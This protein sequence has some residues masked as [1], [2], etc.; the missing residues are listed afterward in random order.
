MSRMTAAQII[1]IGE[2]LN[3]DFDPSSLTVP[4]LLGVFGYHNVNYPSQ[5][6]KAKLVQLFNEEIKP[7]VGKF[8]KERLKRE[9]S[10]ASDDGIKDGITGKPISESKKPVRR[11]SRRSSQAP[12]QAQEPD[13]EPAASKRRRSSA[14]PSL[15]GPSRRKTAKPAEPVVIEESEPEE[16]IVIRKV[17]RSKKSTTDA[18]TQ[19][20]RISQAFAEDSGWEDNNV[21]QSGA[22]SSSPL[23]PSP[24]RTR[25]RRTSVAS[26]LP[27]KSRKSMSAP[28]QYE[29]ASPEKG[30]Q[31]EILKERARSIKPPS[32]RFEPR[33]PPGIARETRATTS[34]ATRTP[35]PE[36]SDERKIIVIPDDVK[37]EEE[38]SDMEM[39][40]LEAL[41][42]SI[43]GPTL[44]PLEV[45]DVIQEEAVVAED[46]DGEDGE[47]QEEV[48][49]VSQ[50]IS[51]GGRIVSRERPSGPG[52]ASLLLRVM[53]VLLALGGSGLFYG[54][55][56]E[57][58]QI[59]FCEAGK[60]SNVI[61]DALRARRA[62]I[63]SCNEHNRTSLYPP[64][65]TLPVSFAEPTPTPQ[66][67][68]GTQD[69]AVYMSDAELC[70]PLPLLP[71]P[72]A[73]ACTP[74][75]RHA[76]CVPD[77]VTCDS[78]YVLK[79]HPLL[80]FMPVPGTAPLSSPS[81]R[82]LTTFTRPGSI[83]SPS[84]DLP[85]LVYSAVSMVLDGVPGI[86]PVAFPPRCVEDPRRRRHIGVLGKAVEALLA[87][88]RGRRLCE[89]VG[90][91][92]PEG[93]DISEAKKWGLE[94]ERL[95]EDLRRK[96]APNLLPT[97]DD[98]FNEAIQQLL[99]WGGVFMG[100]DADGKRFLA[101][102][103][104]SMSWDCAL[105]VK[106]RDAWEE[107]RSSV[108]GSA[109]LILS[110]LGLRRRRAQNTA[111]N[112][113]V[114]A[115]VQVALDL[116]RN[117][118]LAHHTDPVTAPHPYLSSLQLR[119]LILQDE[120][121]VRVRQRLWTRVERVVESNANVRTNLEEVKG[122]DEL[123]VWRWVGS[124]GAIG[125]ASGAKD[126]NLRIAA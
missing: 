22:E 103:T 7:K 3:P 83:L 81:S 33:L 1:S 20:R 125:P 123:R 44:E 19:A 92:E 57:S 62:A 121:S 64:D 8:K 82:Y 15:G 108:V 12:V 48:A 10:Q 114:A 91:G 79:S 112:E 118:E 66:S 75:P 101:H 89:G 78:G 13:L 68:S 63:E 18:A 113:R 111:E 54:H 88:E 76:T 115:L 35:G 93:D 39:K 56:R 95:K 49:A 51:E 119:D 80:S 55:K 100:E 45:P 21:F 105:K 4:Q 110:I 60:S 73:D 27:V 14:Q 102:R 126:E 72:Q 104:P 94:L 59:G 71:L 84:A 124:A 67:S 85:E 9:N 109:V 58:A 28:P 42:Q 52:P 23:R 96:T 43:T 77:I 40:E 47:L 41:R 87:S 50:R 122:G 107:W 31:P 30:K 70:P 65:S 106:A 90:V 116:L 53:L 37:E 61:L 36:L 2:Y 29:Q 97:L 117:Q 86:G 74:C 5:H 99:N 26:R 24:V 98:T 34:R 6:T 38:V 16:D 11:S 32:S 69:G 17:S 25:Q 46:D 120:H